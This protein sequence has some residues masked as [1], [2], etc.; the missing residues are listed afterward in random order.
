MTEKFTRWVGSLG[1]LEL[2]L[3]RIKKLKTMAEIMTAVGVKPD[4]VGCE[5]CRPAVG[6]ILSSL[7]NDHIVNPVH[8]S[9]VPH[10]VPL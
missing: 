3:D 5:I 1:T 6:S 8:N 7:W 4:S 9:S 10:T 2:I